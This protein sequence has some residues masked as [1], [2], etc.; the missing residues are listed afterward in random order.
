[1]KLELDESQI[2][3]VVNVGH[4]KGVIDTGAE[5][6]LC[7]ITSSVIPMIYI[8]KD[9]WRDTVSGVGG[10]LSG[11]YFIIS[12]LEIDCLKFKNVKIFAP[13]KPIKELKQTFLLGID[14]WQ[15]I[16]CHYHFKSKE[17]IVE[18][19]DDVRIIDLKN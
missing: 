10:S 6:S 9:S 18:L 17:F 12:E 15:N 2:R 8:V 4:F 3:P 7:N 16:D 19:P 5:S 1:M 11:K 13:D 14:I